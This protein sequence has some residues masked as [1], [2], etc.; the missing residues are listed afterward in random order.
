MEHKK[1]KGVSLTLAG[2]ALATLGIITPIT[3]DWWNTKSD[4]TITKE[5]RVNLIEQKTSVDGLKITYLGRDIESLSKIVFTLKNTGRTPIESSDLV[6][7]PTLEITDGE[8]LNASI[9]IMEP[10]NLG[11]TITQN[12]NTVSIKFPLLNPE[13]FIKFSIL[14]SGQSFSYK[15]ES[16]IK[17]ISKITSLDEKDQ[18]KI[19]SSF[20]FGT[21]V[22]AAFVILFLAIFLA[23]I[24]DIPKRKRAYKSLLKEEP[25][26][27]PGEQTSTTIFYIDNDLRF[28]S[29][30]KRTTLRA[31]ATRHGSALEKDNSSELFNTTKSLLE[32]YNP[33][34]GAIVVLFPIIA[35]SYYIY[36]S[37]FI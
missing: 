34:A 12:G 22:V 27:H 24:A 28:L 23:L 4:L 20:G 11:S 25:P 7:P 32:A 3:W 13:D 6:S 36:S 18:I 19:R 26:F 29:K 30:P 5:Q 37:I 9:E 1:T 33:A 14:V 2:L 16:R 31:I 35:G 17:N 15:I 8:L 21:Y 10:E